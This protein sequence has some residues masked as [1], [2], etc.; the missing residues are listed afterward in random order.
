MK[1][2]RLLELIGDE[3]VFE[4]SLLL[5]GK[6]SPENVRL[7]LTRWAK[8]GWIYQLRR[9][10]YSIAPPYQKVKPHPFV[11]ANRMRRASYVSAQSALAFYGL[12]PETMHT[13]L[14]VTASRPERLVTPLGIFEFQHIKPNL[15][16]GYR[17]TD[18]NGQQA[19]V[20]TPEKAL[21][22]LVYLQSGGDSDDYLRELRLQNLEQFN[23]D[24]LRIL[25]DSFDTPK[26]RRAVENIIRLVQNE[27]QEYETLPPSFHEGAYQ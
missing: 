9:G 2:E 23:L 3:P 14:S 6:V 7:Q 8:S 15:L 5:A 13:T 12:I 21:L 17:M 11:I 4:T 25:A 24:T 19:L 10:L 20:A 16:R 1:Y 26:L 22:D 27:I 18:L